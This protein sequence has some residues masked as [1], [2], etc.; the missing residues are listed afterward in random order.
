M[1]DVATHKVTNHF[2][3]DDATH[4]YRVNGGAPDP[5]GK[6]LYASTTEITKQA[7]RYTLGQPKYTIIDLAQQKIVKTVDEP[8]QAPEAVVAAVAAADA[9][10]AA[11]KSLPMANI[12]TSSAPRSRC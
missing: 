1:I 4:R 6:V 11:S 8:T 3:L 10:A 7:D 12:S 9:A 5:E 2:V